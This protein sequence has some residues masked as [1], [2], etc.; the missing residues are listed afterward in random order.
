MKK[1]NIAVLGAT[2]AVGQ[3]ML[4]VLAEYDLPVDKL[5]P[6]GSARSAGKKIVFKGQEV[7]IQEATDECFRGMDFVLGAVEGD[8]SKRF[9]PAMRHTGTVSRR[10]TKRM[11]PRR[12]PKC[13]KGP[14]RRARSGA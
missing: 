7:E 6:L 13:G 1:L 14:G 11:S 8:M 12:S 3:E 10:P 4:K 9:A 5:L 2:G